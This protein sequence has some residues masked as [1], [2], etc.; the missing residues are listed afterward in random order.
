MWHL[1]IALV[2]VVGVGTFEQVAFDVLLQRLVEIVLVTD[3]D[4]HSHKRL[5][6]RVPADT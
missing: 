5:L 6:A 2:A 4:A 1:L 3:V